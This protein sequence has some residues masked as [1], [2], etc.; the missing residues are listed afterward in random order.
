MSILILVQFSDQEDFGFSTRQ[1][2]SNLSSS[3]Q[4]IVT[5]LDGPAILD[6]KWSHSHS[7]LLAIADANGFTE[8]FK[9]DNGQLT[10]QSSLSNLKDQVLNL[11]LDCSDRLSNE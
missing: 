2:L 11:S 4:S 1:V 6:I 10:K 9:F 5:Y 8:L 7:Q 3:H